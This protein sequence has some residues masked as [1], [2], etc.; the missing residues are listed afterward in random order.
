MSMDLD[1]AQALQRAADDRGF[2][3]RTPSPEPVPLEDPL[4]IFDRLVTERELRDTTRDLFRNGHFALAV[5][6]AFKYV[7]NLVKARSGLATD[8]QSL[9]NSA[10]SPASPVLKLNPLTTQSQKDQQLGYMQ[11]LAGC[12]TGVRNPRAHEHRYLDEPHIALE[13]LALANHLS[14]LVNAATRSRRRS[15]AARA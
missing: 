15:G 2:G 8:G 13:L 14:R 9:M 7:N 10:F 12:M 11:I 1:L 3:P 5:E 6:E 4:A